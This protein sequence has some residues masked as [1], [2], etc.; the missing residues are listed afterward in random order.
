MAFAVALELADLVRVLVIPR[1]DFLN[2]K[3]V[4]VAGMHV[5]IY[6]YIYN[7]VI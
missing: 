4:I 5:C 6:I 3:K 1:C 2:I 7:I